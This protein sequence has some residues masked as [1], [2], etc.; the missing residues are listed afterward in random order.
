[1]GYTQ[2]WRDCQVSCVAFIALVYFL[3]TNSTSNPQFS[4]S[5]LG[6]QLKLS[7]A[8]FLVG[9]SSNIATALAAARL[10]GLPSERV[11]LMDQDTMLN[12]VPRISTV[13]DLIREGLRQELVFE[14]RNLDP[15][16][17]RKKVALLSWSSGTT[18]K[19]KV[20]CVWLSLTSYN[21]A[22]GKTL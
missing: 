17:G 16:E 2:A 1:M 7:K 9:N 14:E 22:D 21:L 3:T 19:P 11:V 8:S 12:R 5:E 18:G 15:G 10:A 4:V 20:N 6:Y 13:D